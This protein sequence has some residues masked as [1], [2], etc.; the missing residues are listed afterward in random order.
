MSEYQLSNLHVVTHKVTGAASSVW[1]GAQ[2][3]K[4]SLN[5]VW[6]WTRLSDPRGPVPS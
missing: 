3:V 1:W 6:G 2:S 5:A 4:R